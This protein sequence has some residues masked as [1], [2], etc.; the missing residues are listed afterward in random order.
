MD[1][2]IHSWSVSYREAV[3]GLYQPT[4]SLFEDQID[5]GSQWTPRQFAAFSKAYSNREVVALKRR[6]EREHGFEYDWVF[7][8][9]LDIHIEK[10]VDYDVIDNRRFYLNGPKQPH[11]SSCRCWFCD[12]TSPDHCVDDL[13]FFSNSRDMD[14]FASLFGSLEEIAVTSRWSNHII[15]RKHLQRTGLWERA[16][17]YF[18]TI[19]NKYAHIWFLLRVPAPVRSNTPLIRWRFKKWYIK[20]LHTCIIVTK[21]DVIYCYAEVGIRRLL[22]RK[23]LGDRKT[24]P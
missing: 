12:E 16:A 17:Y 6:H 14:L 3:N 8:T 15:I 22:S 7:L 13:V 23:L 2:F 10:K 4:A 21:L 24:T 9:R 5:F 1:V 18:T 20:L 19:P 11:G